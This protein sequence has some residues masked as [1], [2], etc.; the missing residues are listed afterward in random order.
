MSESNQAPVQAATPS[1]NK[2]AVKRKPWWRMFSPLFWITVVIPTVCAVVYFSVW[3]SDQYISESSF[4]VRSARN[5]ASVGGL[6]ALLQSA[7]LSRSQDDTYTVQEYIRSRTALNELQQ[8][9][10]VR[11]YYENEGDIF[12]R[13]NPIGLDNSE[14]AFY[15]YYLKRVGVSLDALSGISVLTVQSFKPEESQAVNQALLAKAEHLINQLNQR[16]RRDTVEFAQQSIAVAEERVKESA[17]NLMEYRTKN[18]IFDLKE[19]SA[20]Q[21]G[22]V[23]KL[24]DELIVIQTQLDQVRAVTPDNPQIPGLKAR[25]QSLRREIAQQMQKISGSGDHSIAAKAAEYQRLYI[26]N[27]LAEKQ[28][29]AA[30]SSLEAAK[31][32]ADRQQL[33]LEVI[34]Q[35][36]KPDM[37]QKPERLYNI[38]A[39]LV[40]GLMAYGILSLLIA[41]VREH[42]N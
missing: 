11:S 6:G 13:F 16:A 23:S 3:A 26:E 21:M 34:S 14:E 38:I 7:G 32:E 27:E 1:E 36:N 8:Q 4:V 30:I 35:P 42:K 12:S 25:E 10:P 29:A 5:Q 15:E 28:L 39:V 18:G 22:L 9:L 33:Y 17:D 19:Q 20:V 24:Q 41:S 2:R 31:A 40:I 37:A